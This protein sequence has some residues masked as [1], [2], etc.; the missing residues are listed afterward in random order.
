MEERE[1]GMFHTQWLKPQA[2]R[3]PGSA[4][5]LFCFVRGSVPSYLDLSHYSLSLDQQ[6]TNE[7]HETN[8]LPELQGGRVHSCRSKTGKG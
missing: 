3:L 5:A 4:E 6:H 8:A 2:L 7:N 1:E